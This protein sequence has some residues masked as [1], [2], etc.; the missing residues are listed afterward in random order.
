MRLHGHDELLQCTPTA[1]AFLCI[2]HVLL[3]SGFGSAALLCIQGGLVSPATIVFF[4]DITAH[5]KAPHSGILKAYEPLIDMGVLIHEASMD[6][7]RD[8]AGNPAA[9]CPRL[10]LSRIVFSGDGGR[11]SSNIR[12]KAFGAQSIRSGSFLGYVKSFISCKGGVPA[13]SCA[14]SRL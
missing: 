7:G 1:R 8:S 11:R 3:A 5:P 6:Y 10:G 4:D 2:V 13:G 14:T 12:E 9:V